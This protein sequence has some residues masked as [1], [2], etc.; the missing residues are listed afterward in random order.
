VTS[1]A[2]DAVEV[3]ALLA[4]AR[5]TQA[6]MDQMVMARILSKSSLTL[7]FGPMSIPR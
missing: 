4:H 1:P 6:M 3:I 5:L 2:V 7:G